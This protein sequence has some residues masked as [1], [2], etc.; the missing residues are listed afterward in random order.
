MSSIRGF[1]TP[2]NAMTST[3]LVAGFLGLAALADAHLTLAAAL[4]GLAAICDS[5]DGAIARRKGGDSAFGMN[6]DSLADLLS[7][8]VVPAMALYIGPLNSQPFLGLV[9]CSGF[10]LAA[11]WRLAR[12]PLVK[13]CN[14]FMG[15]PLPAAGVLLMIMM[16]CRPG[17]GVA[18]VATLTASAL[19]VSTLHF[20]TLRGVGR[21]TSVVLRGDYGRRPPRL[22][23][24][25][26]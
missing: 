17:L 19:M 9:T 3:N 21:A 10:V 6:L 7:F 25:R 5:L 14:Y 2:A 4:V 1:L 26:G 23:D 20:P 24:R 22:K 15:L 11:A 12:F 18:L 13:R 8:G 16:L